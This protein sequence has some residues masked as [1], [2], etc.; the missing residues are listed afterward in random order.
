MKVESEKGL[1]YLQIQTDDLISIDLSI[2]YYGVSR[3]L[4]P[5]SETNLKT[6]SFTSLN[7]QTYSFPE[8][9]LT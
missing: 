5:N 9:Q 6:I 3:A 2:V 1:V 7:F 8:N 4:V